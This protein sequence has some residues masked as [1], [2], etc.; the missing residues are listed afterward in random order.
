MGKNPDVRY[1]EPRNEVVHAYSSHKKAETVFNINH[2]T[3]LQSGL[4]K[5]AEWVKIHGAKTTKNFDEIEIEE[6]LPPFWKS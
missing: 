4:K 5:M 2:K 3:D 6:G 1:L